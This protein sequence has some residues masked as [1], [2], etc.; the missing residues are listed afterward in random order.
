[1]LQEIQYE[2]RC[3]V[4][5]QL[6]NIQS[7]P[8]HNHSAFQVIY[9]LE[10]EL[11]LKLSYYKYRLQPGSIHIIH[12]EDVHSFESI[13]EDNLVLVISLDSNYFQTVFPHFITTVFITNVEEN[14]LK[15]VDVLRD[16]LFAI[17]AEEMDAS[18]GKPGRVN[19]AAVAMINTLMQHFRGFVIEPSEK[20][21]KHQTSHDYMQVDRISRIIQY[22][23]ENY[24]YKIHLSEIAEREQISAYYLSHVFQKLVGLNFRDF[25]SHVRTEMSEAAILST[26]K[27]ITQIA[28]DVGFSDTKYFVKHFYGYLGCHPKEYRRIYSDKIYG[29]VAPNVEEYPLS[30]LK[31]II[32]KYTQYP[33]FKQEIS[34]VSLVELDFAAKPVGTLK[35][36]GINLDSLESIVSD[37][38]RGTAPDSNLIIHYKDV[39]PHA[40]AISLLQKLVKDP[41]QFRLPDVDLYD[42]TR[43]LQGLLTVNGLKKPMYYLLQMFRNLPEN[44]LSYGPNSIALQ[45]KSTTALLLF[46]PYRSEKITADI[47]TRNVPANCKLTKHMLRAENS[48]L[49]F[50]SQLNFW[51]SLTDEDINNIN[52]MSHPDISFD[53]VPKDEQYYTSIELAP[54]DVITLFFTY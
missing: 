14:S 2:D 6:L 26:N 3:Y 51:P 31:S 12:T 1:M 41:S 49:V 53:M 46:N 40:S 28:Q 16:R 43:K 10:G 13:T 4:K 23:Y 8:I 38:M 45:S 37:L 29:K 21:F 42:S 5:T 15:K 50:W 35:K 54:Y 19:N 22:V 34:P 18:P 24:P 30:K 32:N 27:S 25:V 11:S 44:I 20:A 17:V 39:V 47:V 36:P 48:C 7:Y 52:L 9:V 33:V